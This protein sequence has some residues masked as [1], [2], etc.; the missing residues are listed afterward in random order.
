MMGLTILLPC[1]NEAETIE[2]VIENA[3]ASLKKSGL[4][5]EILVAD[6]GST[7]GSK[8]LAV[9]LGARVV[10][11]PVKGYGSALSHG[12]NASFYDFVIMG[13]ADDSYALDD[14]EL[15]L[16][17]LEAGFD[18]V[19]GNRF[20]GGI[21]EGA[22]PWLH[23]YLGNPILSWLGRLLFKIPIGDFHC[24]LRGFRRISIQQLN[25][26]STGM[27][28]ASEMIVKAKLNNLKIDQVPTIL[29]PDGRSRS[30]H[31]R[32]WRDGWRHL[33][34]L[35]A[36]SPRFLFLYPGIFLFSLGFVGSLLTFSGPIDL[37][38][39]FLDSNSYL[40]S[41]GLILIGLQ[42]IL[43]SILTRIFSSN[44]GMLPKTRSVSTFEKYFTL[45]R[46][47]VLGIFL[48]I[49]SLIGFFVLISDW[50]GD[51]FEHFT[52]S[53]SLRVSGAI[54]LAL[55]SGIQILFASFFAAIL[56]TS[57]I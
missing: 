13:D 6:N 4:P 54:I 20:Q 45:E 23:R 32:T 12:I 30:P 51:G 46:G 21:Q 18:L 14:L 56:Q 19:V 11:V 48:L 17:K 9:L 35:L 57:E 31:L 22:M 40:F 50:T 15:F 26:K 8:Q 53:E 1:L 37:F 34:F 27:E 36:S 25:L 43:M 3:R 28:F 24:G 49:L 55:L 41:I 33:V 2:S 42:T 44:Y 52:S 10:D 38:N 16:E 29:K 7:D 47:I 5:G 39:Y